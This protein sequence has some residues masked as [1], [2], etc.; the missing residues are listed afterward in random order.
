MIHTISVITHHII[1]QV[2]GEVA[3]KLCCPCGTTTTEG[4]H[5]ITADGTNCRLLVLDTGTGKL[6]NTH[7]LQECDIAA[8]LHLINN[9]KELVLR[10]Q[11]QDKERI[12][13]YSIE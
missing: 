2:Q 6:I 13:H 10:Y 4:G 11:H 12:A 7:E 1:L 5:M 3:G 9:D 8:Q